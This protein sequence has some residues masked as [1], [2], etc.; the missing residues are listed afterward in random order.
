MYVC[1]CFNYIKNIIKFGFKSRINIFCVSVLAWGIL[2]ME[3]IYHIGPLTFRPWR[4]LTIVYATPLLICTVLMVFAP[5]SPK[6]LVS[7][8]KHDKALEVLRSIYAINNGQAKELYPV[9]KI[10]LCLK[11]VLNLNNRES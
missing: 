9:R 6:Y 5:E 3:W 2:S 4:L 7:R 1:N 8:G 10:I 11:V